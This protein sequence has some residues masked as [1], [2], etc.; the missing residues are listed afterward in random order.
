MAAVASSKF[1]ASTQR[2]HAVARPPL[3]YDNTYKM[4]PDKKFPQPA[5]KKVINEVLQAMLESEKY[6]PTKCLGLTKQLADLIKDRVKELNIQRFK[7]VCHVYLGSVDNGSLACVS[8]CVW[9]DKFDTSAEGVYK[10]D[11]LF[12]IGVVYGLYSE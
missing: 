7:I 5:V 1:S 10:N 3:R 4:E 6:E 9:N 8:Q 12:G 11:S 2:S